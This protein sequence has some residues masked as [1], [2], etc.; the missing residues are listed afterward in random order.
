[1]DFK[2]F[3]ERYQYDSEKDLLGVGGFGRVYRARDLRLERWVALKVFS[4]D[5]P[6]QY[7]LISEIKRAIHLH[8]PNICRY[9]D[10]EVLRGTNAMGESQVIQVGIMEYVECGT[11]DAFLK[12]QPQ[13]LQKLL[14]DVLRGLS[15]L[16]RRNPPILHRD[17]EPS[18]VLVGM[19]DGVPV[20]KITDFGISKSSSLSGA[21]VS[22][23]GLGTYAYM[24]P[25]QL[26]PAR[27]GVGGKVRCN[28]DLWSFGA[29]TVELLTGV[30]PF[31]AGSAEV[32][33]GEI[34][35]AIIQGIPPRMLAGFEEPYRTVL[36]RCM[37]QAVSERVQTAEEVLALFEQPAVVAVPEP[38]KAVEEIPD[39]PL[40]VEFSEQSIADREYE[41]PLG[42]E[43]REI[44][45]TP[46]FPNGAEGPT[47]P[48]LGLTIFLTIV[49]PVLAGLL[50]WV[51]IV[52]SPQSEAPQ[53]PQPM[54]GSPYGKFLQGEKEVSAG[55]YSSA[56][57]LYKSACGG[58][59]DA[60]CRKAADMYGAGIGAARDS[61]LWETYYGK[62]C[63]LG[64][65]DRC[66]E[67]GNAL[68]TGTSVPKDY[69]TAADFYRKACDDGNAHACGA[70][71]HQLSRGEGIKRDYVQASRDLEKACDLLF[72]LACSE[73]GYLYQDGPASIRDPLDFPKFLDRGCN[74][75]D[76]V[77]CMVLG[78]DYRTGRGV[79][80]DIEKA[81]EFLKKSCDGG[82][83]TACQELKGIPS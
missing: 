11:I 55:N 57:E 69:R 32:S 56:L 75:G 60:S 26:N 33:T 77:A 74:L 25:E 64:F 5:A 45:D 34:F 68:Y 46:T 4:R 53:L 37:V 19:E 21:N 71:G 29:M 10:A 54:P 73:L 8:H 65:P 67:I 66:D 18:N 43:E 40:E 82:S 62:Y 30:T 50:A 52:N 7:D 83:L 31:G 36:S 41:P 22:V 17:L 42:D 49:L 20:A 14:M 51:I 38:A 12:D 23:A 59:D 6:Q 78:D 80:R 72:A 2:E 79:P 28:L 61:H 63:D 27:F 16:H 39:P 70:L 44:E 35:E 1:M 81:K 13:L 15:Y 47:R 9:H 3:R 24:A 48:T 58:G 76:E